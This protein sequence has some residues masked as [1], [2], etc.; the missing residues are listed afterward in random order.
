MEE[1]VQDKNAESRE[2][3]QASEDFPMPK[4]KKPMQYP[5]APPKLTS[6]KKLP[7]TN[8]VPVT[9][10]Q[11][12]NAETIHQVAAEPTPQRS[13]KKFSGTTPFAEPFNYEANAEEVAEETNDFLDS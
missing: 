7:S 6:L 4:A 12:A 9:E 1:Y 10:T 5:R 2:V 13:Q 3:H 8:G 11:Q